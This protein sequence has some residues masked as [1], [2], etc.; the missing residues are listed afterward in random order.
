MS[1][2]LITGMP[3]VGKTTIMRNL[4]SE[5]RNRSI[6]FD[7]FYTEELRGTS[8][9]RCGFDIITFDGR[10]APLARLSG[11]VKDAPAKNRV[12]RYTVCVPEFES[13]ALPA[14]GNRSANLLLLDEIGKMELKSG[15]FEDCLKQIVGSVERHEKLFFVATIPLKA[16]LNIVERLKKVRGVQLFHVTIANRN[17][18]QHQIVEATVR[19]LGKAI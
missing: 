14:L 5:L 3:G 7:G 8:G 4:G 6:P 15:P 9:E 12:G 2:I 17:Q 10:K 13:L 18:L 19:M 11:T 1:L 16:T